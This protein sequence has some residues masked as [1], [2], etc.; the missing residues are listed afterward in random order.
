MAAG[1]LTVFNEFREDIGIKLHNLDTDTFRVALVKSAAN[2]GI[3]PTAATADPRWGAGGTTN[4]LSSEV[5]PGG[6]YTTGGITISDMTWVESAGTTT[7]DSATNPQWLQNAS[8]PTNARWAIIY[9]DT[10]AG[11]EAVGFVDL[12]ADVDMTTGDLTI[13][14]AGTGLFTLA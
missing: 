2:G 1:D 7:W 13:T 8:N 12:G 5:T 3:D 14:W 4:L 9:N 11:K 10:S 6:N